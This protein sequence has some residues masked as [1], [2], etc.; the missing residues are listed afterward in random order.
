[1]LSFR[2]VIGQGRIIEH[3]Q[4]A[5][6]NRQVSH[7][8]IFDGPDGVGKR[9]V[10]ERFAATLQC[11][12]GGVEP[13]G[14]CMSCRQMMSGN[15]PDVSYL[16]REKEQYRVQEMRE[17]LCD[18]MPIKPFAGPYRIFI[19][20]EAERLNEQS[21][22]ALLKTLEEPPEYGVILLLTNNR[23]TLL[24]TIVSRA[25]TLPFLP[26]GEGELMRYLMET[27]ELPDYRARLVAS[28]SGGCPGVAMQY[29]HSEE[30][31]KRK[32]YVSALMKGLPDMTEDRMAEL[33]E[34]FAADK[35]GQTTKLELILFWVRDLMMAKSTG[36][37][38]RLMYAE[39]ADQIM[40]Q[41]RHV[42][43]EGLLKMQQQLDELSAKRR[44]NVNMTTAFWILLMQMGEALR[45]GR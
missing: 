38:S 33:A 26:V 16:T 14:R 21:Q 29:A 22:N 20:D 42:T 8:Y 43:Y 23:E 36:Q 13:C 10:A 6:R 11:L 9:M 35:E 18:Q 24:Q 41:S 15:Q 44:A 39:D 37:T 2:D 19:V 27:E 34:Q 17:Q 1:M 12:E 45:Q 40:E 5:I 25:V 32:D 3:L 4:K 31:Q 30:F 7:A 28:F